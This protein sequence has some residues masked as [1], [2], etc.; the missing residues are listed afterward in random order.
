M[1][2]TVL[3]ETTVPRTLDTWLARFDQPEWRGA[4]VEGWLFEGVAARRAAQQ[5][6]Q[7]AGVQATLRSAYKPLVHFFLEEVDRSAL[8]AV[9]VRYP[10]HPQASAGRFLL[11][12]YPLAA[13]LPGCAL[14]FEAGG[15]DLHYQ[16]ALAWKDGR[17][18]QLDVFAPNRIHIGPAGNVLLSPTGWLRVR[19]GTAPATALDA[20]QATEHEQVFER[21]LQAVNAHAWP[22]TEPYFQRLD[23]RVDLP[24]IEQPLPP[25]EE[26]IST[27]EA[28]HEDLYF[29][30]LESFQRRSGRAPGD[31]RLQPGQIVPDIRASAGVPRLRI[32]VRDFEPGP[33][34]T[35][36]SASASA[37][38]LDLLTTAPDSARIAAEMERLGGERF[39]ATSLQGRAVTGLYH[40]GP[41]APV[42]ISGGQHAN[43]TSG[44]VGAL[45]AANALRQQG[46]AHFA[47]VALENPDGYALQRELA[48]H[49]PGHMHHAA[50]Y[51]A[52]GDDIEFREQQP[53]YERGAR[54]HAIAVSGAQLHLNLHGYPAHEWTRPWSGYLPQGFELWTVPKGFFL[55]LR[56]HP[57]WQAEARALVQQVCAELAKVPGLADFNARQ[58]AL[59]QRHA[60]SVPFEVIGGIAC[61][62]SEVD[63]PGAPVTLITEFPDETIHGDAFRFAHTV[64]MRTVLAAARAWQ[65]LARR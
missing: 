39:G 28:L 11:E 9:T 49:H 29:A 55:I 47:L 59:Y 60:G 7:A 52:L 1:T 48:A 35:I 51:S 15:A 18:Q 4:S 54:Q 23:I 50:R 31:R 17:R 19:S 22:Q 20:A 24:G 53:W 34:A 62:V 37:E 42:Y 64:Q 16:L 46:G 27:H 32:A 65:T 44:I 45:R 3:L 38:P 61:S 58:L 56:H 43:E 8:A 14:E 63:R 41:A 6:L 2:A 33:P 21:V 26:C 57:G 5:R 13:M 25:L 30:L 10:V 12:A 40:R 36:A